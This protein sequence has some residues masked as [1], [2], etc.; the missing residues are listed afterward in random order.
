GRVELGEGVQ[1]GHD[2]VAERLLELGRAREVDVVDPARERVD[3]LL[4]EVE[5]ELPLRPRQRDPDLAPEPCAPPLR[6]ELLHRAARVARRERAAPDG[7]RLRRRLVARSLR[8]L[9]HGPPR[10]L[11]TCGPHVR[12]ALNARV[13][14]PTANSRAT[15]TPKRPGPRTPHQSATQPTPPSRSTQTSAGSELRC[16]VSA[17]CHSSTMPEPSTSSRTS[18]SRARVSEPS[19]RNASASSSAST[20]KSTKWNEFPKNP[21]VGP[22]GTTPSSE[23]EESH[24]IRPACATAR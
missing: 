20:P 19:R 5:A 17:W 4:G 3:L 7:A 12:H 2:V 10:P 22:A 23:F 16:G 9:R 21:Q 13:I 1:V 15:A 8:P 18:A 11:V 24:Q 14:P 6:E